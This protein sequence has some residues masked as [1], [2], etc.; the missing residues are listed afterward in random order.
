MRPLFH[1]IKC[2]TADSSM[3]SQSRHTHVD[4]D[5]VR[6]CGARKHIAFF[7]L[8]ITVRMHIPPVLCSLTGLGSGGGSMYDAGLQMRTTPSGQSCMVLDII[9]QWKGCSRSAY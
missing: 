7:H 6:L 8:V 9:W 1:L 2:R 5:S 3:F 4:S